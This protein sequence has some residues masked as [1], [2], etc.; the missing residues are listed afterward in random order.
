M[1][2]LI[3]YFYCRNK[4]VY[5]YFWAKSV[6]LIL[7][8]SRTFIRVTHENN[9]TLLHKNFGQSE[10]WQ[11]NFF[12]L[13]AKLEKTSIL[14]LEWWMLKW[15]DFKARE[16]CLNFE[17]AV[18]CTIWLWDVENDVL[19]SQSTINQ[20]SR[21]KSACCSHRHQQGCRNRDHHQ[22]GRHHHHRVTKRV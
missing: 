15:Y 22:Q 14:G 6:I 20:R 9:E 21:W 16:N 13:G 18:R 11:E 4:K 5:L 2:N 1:L 12:C 17:A 19:K 10:E 8:F 3:I 7:N